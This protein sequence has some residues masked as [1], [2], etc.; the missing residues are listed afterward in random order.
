[1]MV[2]MHKLRYFCAYPKETLSRRASKLKENLCMMVLMYK[3]GYF[4]AY[5]KVPLCT[6]VLEQKKD[7]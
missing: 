1:M 2:L 6:R 7:L 4:P 5:P 3:L